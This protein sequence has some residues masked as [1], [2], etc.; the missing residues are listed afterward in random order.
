[1]A[2]VF[3]KR[4]IADYNPHHRSR[5]YLYRVAHSLTRD[6]GYSPYVPWPVCPP[7]TNGQTKTNKSSRNQ[8]FGLPICRNHTTELPLEHSCIGNALR[9]TTAT[10]H[11]CRPISGP[12]RTGR[13]QLRC[14]RDHHRHQPSRDKSVRQ[15]MQPGRYATNLKEAVPNCSTN[16]KRTTVTANLLPF[17]KSFSMK[18]PHALLPTDIPQHHQ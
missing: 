13:L 14:W 10:G 6:P 9:L 18:S 16:Y 4:E 1:M 8:R 3:D 7:R 11:N 2:I 12:W 15:K 5:H 17:N